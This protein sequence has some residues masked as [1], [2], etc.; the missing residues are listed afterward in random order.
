MLT[1]FLDQTI[2]PVVGIVGVATVAVCSKLEFQKL[3]AVS[4][5]VSGTV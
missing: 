3:V 4:S 5:S 2:V 1:F